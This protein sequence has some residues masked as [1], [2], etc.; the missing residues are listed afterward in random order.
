MSFRGFDCINLDGKGRFS[1]PTKHR[2]ELEEICQGKL[3]VT[4]SRDICLAL[5]PLPV[6]EDIESKLVKVSALNASAMKLKRF[7]LG[8]AC[9]CEMDA[10][11]RI[12]LQEELRE[13]AGIDKRIVLSSLIDRFEIWDHESWQKSRKSWMDDEI[14]LEELNDFAPNLII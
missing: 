13:F 1:I 14:S 6:W 9:E 12:L 3:V 5:Y 11:G 8:H 4:A 10:Q 7:M 2:A